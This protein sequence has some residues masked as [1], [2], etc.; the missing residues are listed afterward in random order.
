MGIGK[1]IK[2]QQRAKKDAF[3]MR[4]YIQYHLDLYGLGKLVKVD[5]PKRGGS[6]NDQGWYQLGVIYLPP[7]HED[8]AD[9]QFYQKRVNVYLGYSTSGGYWN[10]R[11]IR[12]ALESHAKEIR[13]TAIREETTH[14]VWHSAQTPLQLT[15]G[16]S[17]SGAF[18]L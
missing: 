1:R 10:R 3:N 11:N 9:V 4:E 14:K 8:E 7:G 12:I 6:R 16:R 17:K 18:E 2:E 15:S 13:Q 5:G